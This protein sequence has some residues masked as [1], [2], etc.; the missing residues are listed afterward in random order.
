MCQNFVNNYEKSKEP[1]EQSGA[2]TFYEKRDKED[3][4]LDI[5]KTIREQF[6][7]LRIV[8][9]DDYPAFFELEGNRYILKIELDESM[10]G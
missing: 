9:N 2:E 6:N 5:D 10:G 7:L 4:K 1:I 3:S 8:N